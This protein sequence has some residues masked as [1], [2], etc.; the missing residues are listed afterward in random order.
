MSVDKVRKK[1]ARQRDTG[2]NDWP[3][4]LAAPA[5]RA[6]SKAGLTRLEQLSA[7]SE[8]EL[9]RMHGIGPRALA[10]LRAALADKGLSFRTA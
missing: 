1:Q 3:A 6:L 10:L 5:Q 2:K 7:I 4:G 8:D 9:S